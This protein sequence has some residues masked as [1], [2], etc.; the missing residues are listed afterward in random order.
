MISIEVEVLSK[1]NWNEVVFAGAW[2]FVLCTIVLPMVCI[3]GTSLFIAETLKISFHTFVDLPGLTVS[4]GKP[5]PFLK[6]SFP[7]RSCLEISYLY[8]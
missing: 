3:Y 2:K 6:K 8:L 7:S 1:T 4:L 5:Y